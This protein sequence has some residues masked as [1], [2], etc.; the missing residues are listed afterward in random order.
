MAPK[1]LRSNRLEESALLQR[2]GH[3]LAVAVPVPY[4]PRSC[5]RALTLRASSLGSRREMA[6]ASGWSGPSRVIR[7]GT[8]RDSFS[9]AADRSPSLNCGCSPTPGGTEP[10]GALD[11]GRSRWATR[12]GPLAPSRLRG[13]AE[14]GPGRRRTYVRNTKA[15]SR[16]GSFEIFRC[17]RLSTRSIRRPQPRMRQSF[18]R[19]GIERCASSRLGREG[20]DETSISTRCGH[21]VSRHWPGVGAQSKTWPRS[22]A[23]RME[24]SRAGSTRPAG[25]DSLPRLLGG[26]GA[27]CSRGRP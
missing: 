22:T 7:D 4:A 20:L 2:V 3:A 23:R 8:S 6:K 11:R 21:A 1:N 27:G 24:L 13:A 26:E 5:R 16:P 9:S 12:N 14:S 18:R 15:V 19:G 10:F 17:E 25:R